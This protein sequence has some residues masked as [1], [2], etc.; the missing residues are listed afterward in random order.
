M[1]TT[2]PL[3]ALMLAAATIAAQ[4]PSELRVDA[5]FDGG[6][7][8]VLDIDQATRTVAFQPPVQPNGGWRC[9]WYFRVTGVTPGETLTL[10]MSGAQAPSDRPVYSLD[11]KAW[12]FME[13]RNKQKIAGNAAY[14]A[15]YVPYVPANAAEIC[16][17][18]EKQSP[19]AKKFELCRS[20]EDRP[21]W[22]IRITEPGDESRRP[23]VWIHARQHAWEVGSSWTA[24]GMIRWLMSDDPAA[25]S[26]RRS[27]VIYVVP[28]MDVDNVAKG[29]GG[30]EQ[31]PHDHNRDWKA[32]P[33]WKSVK[34]TQ[35]LLQPF[36]DDR[37]LRVFLDFHN[38]GY[39]SGRDLEFWCTG[40]K[41]FVS[42]RKTATD[43]FLKTVRGELTGPIQFKG[44]ISQ[45]TP[46][47]AYTAGRWAR[48]RTPV[49]AVS[50]C[51]EIPCAAPK[52]F[53]GNP[54]E[55][56]LQLGAQLGRSIERFL[57]GD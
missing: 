26:L 25:K 21:V 3:L 54:P 17:W 14:F 57:R 4:E 6:A 27:A 51:F 12:K 32:K 8:K 13:T 19:A 22:A 52:T 24:D 2:L 34:A 33:V 49:E 1:R 35:D 53:Q 41:D 18:A 29:L 50:G 43:A 42:E 47:T 23:V 7:A 5:K 55:H 36:L 30:K 56:Q 28:I 31:R 10:Q 45:S 46:P 15:W 11:G 38:P 48:E 40:Y 39:G 44:V 37:R 16:D 9:W 20:E